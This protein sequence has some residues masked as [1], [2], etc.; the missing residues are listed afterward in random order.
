MV[1]RGL[2]GV[3]DEPRGDTLVRAHALIPFRTPH[4]STPFPL[5]LRLKT[6][7]SPLQGKGA[8][9][10]IVLSRNKICWQELV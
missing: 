4:S 3:Q 2:K 6:E 1:V 8:E 9:P 10:A 5:R 7:R